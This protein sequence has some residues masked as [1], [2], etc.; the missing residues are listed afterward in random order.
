MCQYC[1]GAR[2]GQINPQNSHLLTIFG[3]Q[4]PIQA[5]RYLRLQNCVCASIKSFLFKFYL[6]FI[7][8]KKWKF[9]IKCDLKKRQISF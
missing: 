3:A 4:G 9:F 5:T 2:V 7:S 6:D 1:N 8:F